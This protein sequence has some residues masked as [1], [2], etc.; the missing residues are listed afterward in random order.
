[1]RASAGGLSARPT[2]HPPESRRTRAKLLYRRG[3]ILRA[4]S[5]QTGGGGAAAAATDFAEA[6]A[7]APQDPL[8]R[9]ALTEARTAAKAEQRGSCQTVKGNL[10]WAAPSAAGGTGGDDSPI[11]HLDM[12]TADMTGD[13]APPSSPASLP[14]PPTPPS[15][16]EGQ[17]WR[18]AVA[19]GLPT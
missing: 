12:T 1:M 10:H 16:A 14:P 15:A 2:I 5:G 4:D 8:M 9:R 6:C 17:P 13:A 11:E 19:H 18:G 7:L 3:T